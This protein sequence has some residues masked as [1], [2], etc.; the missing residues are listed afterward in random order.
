VTRVSQKEVTRSAEE[1][2]AAL[3]L[4]QSDNLL[5][6]ILADFDRCG[7]VGEHT[8]RRGRYL[9]VVCRPLYSVKNFKKNF[10]K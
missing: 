1:D 7:I 6:R 3:S 8:D 2:S 4:L 10:K 9:A 5:D